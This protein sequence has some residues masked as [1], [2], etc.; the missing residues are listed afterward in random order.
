MPHIKL[1]RLGD[2]PRV[3][4]GRGAPITPRDQEAHG[5]F[6]LRQLDNVKRQ[7]RRGLANRQENLPAV[8]AGIQFLI[9]GATTDSGK[10]LLEG[11]KLKGLKLEVIEERRDGLFLAVSLDPAANRFGHTIEWFTDDERT[12]TGRRKSGVRQIFEI[13]E[14]ELSGPLSKKGDELA[15]VDIRANERYVVDIEVAA[16]REH[17]SSE[18]R[19]HTFSNYLLDAEGQLIGNGV[20]VEED[21]ALF[22][23]R[24]SGRVIDDILNFHPW[25]IS[26]D[27]LPVL[28]R[29]GFDLNDIRRDE[30][31]PIDPAPENAP[32]V[33]V[34]DGGI[35]PEHPLVRAS[36]HALQHESFLPGNASVIDMGA[37]GHGT[38]V[39]SVVGLSSLRDALLNGQ[40]IT[41]VR[42]V[43]A[44]VLDDNTRVPEN[45]NLKDVIPRAAQ[46]MRDTHGA[47]IA[48]HSLASRAPFNRNRM[49]IWGETL[50]R[51]SYDEGGP[52]F[53][54]ITATGNIDGIITPTIA[55]VE[56]WLRDQGHPRFLLDERCR[57]RNP[58]QAINV[59]TVGA[60]IPVAGVPFHARAGLGYQHVGQTSQPSPFTRTG[61]GYLNETKPEVVEE[62][63]NWYSDEGGRLVRQPQITD[64]AVANSQFAI[65]GRLVKFETGTSL[66]APRVAHLAARLLEVLPA[67]GVDL[68]RSLIVNSASWPAR[69]N[70]VE[71]TLRLYGYGV[72]NKARAM[73]PG[74]PRALMFVEDTIRIGHVQFF[75]IPF[76]TDL[77]DATPETRIRVSV[78][79]AY[80]APVRKSSRRYRGT[81]LEWKF[82]KRGEDLPH[83][84]QRCAAAPAI[85][86]EEVDED[87]EEGPIGNWNWTVGTQIR[88]RGTVQKDWFEAAA[89][90]FG[91]ELFLAVIGRRGWLSKKQQ[92]EGFDQVYAISICIEAIG[93]A[94]PIHERIEA[95]VRV[96]VA[97]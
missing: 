97:V 39:V 59:L 95:L 84:K 63:G 27:L 22:R 9:Q 78:T 43:V 38:A 72:P 1:P 7:L 30:L 4:Q 89:T 12:Q 37:D 83:F 58:A 73:E 80:R 46:R 34:L 25:V 88:N 42:T 91:D 47:R 51:L 31:P 81:V 94:V 65:T 26:V 67:A 15:L 68:L 92:D 90:E 54:I 48:N 17:P 44:R 86:T 19:R 45:L 29:Q 2:E 74:G 18:E 61:F 10:V 13:E 87:V 35:I 71:D 79:L 8:P 77:F 16:G 75:R 60:Y 64:V 36:L 49:S 96:A 6:L 5:R 85:E 50:D 82:G 93:V 24:I 53:L 23:V 52:G 62:G 55:Q 14:V 32:I 69:L 70:S 40:R 20:I 76:P 66:A 3:V 33:T 57:L 41:P 56:D 21:Y 28:E 11:A